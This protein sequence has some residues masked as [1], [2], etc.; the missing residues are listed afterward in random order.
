[1]IVRAL[2]EATAYIQ[3]TLPISGETALMLA[4]QKGHAAVCALLGA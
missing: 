2:I 4:Q 1:M 3:A